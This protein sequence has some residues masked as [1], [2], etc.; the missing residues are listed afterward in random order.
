MKHDVRLGVLLHSV[1]TAVLGR[2][3][4]LTPL[5]FAANCRRPSVCCGLDHRAAALPSPGAG[6][7]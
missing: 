6:K 5:F 7:R 1:L 4:G 2:Q 3:D